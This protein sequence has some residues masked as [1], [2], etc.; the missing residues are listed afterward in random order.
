MHTPTKA[1]WQIV[2]DNFKKVLPLAEKN[3]NRHL[4]MMETIVKNPY[5]TCGT[6][7][8]AGGWY[9]IATCNLESRESIY[10]QAGVN[11]M[12]EDLGFFCREQL[13]N[14]AMRNPIIWGNRNGGMM[15]SAEKAYGENCN[16]LADIIKHLEGVRDRSPD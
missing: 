4:D 5:H 13:V 2:I 3:S 11:N 12:V 14:W 6:I 10:Y 1:Q 16:T 8:C 7:H 9:A 15:F